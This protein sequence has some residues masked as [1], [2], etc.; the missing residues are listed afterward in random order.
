MKDWREKYANCN[1][2]AE[3]QDNILLT[4]MCKACQCYNCEKIRAKCLKSEWCSRD[5]IEI[6]CG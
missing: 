2:C 3:Y 4:A 5:G 6:K 1:N